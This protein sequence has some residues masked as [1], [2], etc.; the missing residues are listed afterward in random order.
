MGCLF[1]LKKGKQNECWAKNIPARQEKHQGLR[2]HYAEA[3][4]EKLCSKRM[5]KSI[6]GSLLHGHPKLGAL[7]LKGSDR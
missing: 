5:Q 4:K 6:L 1:D 2:V 3:R 7:T